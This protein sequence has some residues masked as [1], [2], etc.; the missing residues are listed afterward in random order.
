MIPFTPRF[1]GVPTATDRLANDE[2]ITKSVSLLR[3]AVADAAGLSRDERR[4]LIINKSKIGYR[5]GLERH[6]VV[7]L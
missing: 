3:T 6:E 7:V 2:Q 1:R 5:L 4:T